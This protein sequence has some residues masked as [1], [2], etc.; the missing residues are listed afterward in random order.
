[1]RTSDNRFCGWITTY[2][3]E[4]RKSFG[5]TKLAHFIPVWISFTLEKDLRFTSRF[6]K[7]LHDTLDYEFK[8]NLIIVLEDILRSCTIEFKGCWEKYLSLFEFTY[9]NNY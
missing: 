3:K 7:K 1:M 5:L 8:L 2:S 9:N 6:W 4:K